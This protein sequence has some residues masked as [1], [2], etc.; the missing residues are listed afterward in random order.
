M[1]TVH[2]TSAIL[3]KES[4]PWPL[5]H[6]MTYPRTQTVRDLNQALYGLY[7]QCKGTDVM[8]EKLNVHTAVSKSN[9]LNQDQIINII[10]PLFAVAATNAKSVDFHFERSPYLLN[11]DKD[12]ANVSVTLLR[13]YCRFL[14]EQEVY[15]RLRELYSLTLDEVKFARTPPWINKNLTSSPAGCTRRIK[16]LDQLEIMLSKK[17]TGLEKA[18]DAPE[19]RPMRTFGE[20]WE[21]FMKMRKERAGQVDTET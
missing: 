18:W 5:K 3:E 9:W 14:Q 10:S 15:V 12:T 13:K 6:G 19:G 4:L 7:E 21:A 20:R 16:S 8:L 17:E 11:M 1:M 2:T